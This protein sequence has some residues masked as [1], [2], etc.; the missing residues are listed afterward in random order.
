MW[1]AFLPQTFHVF[2]SGAS[3]VFSCCSAQRQNNRLSMVLCQ[4]PVNNLGQCRKGSVLTFCVAFQILTTGLFEVT[5]HLPACSLSLSTS[6][7]PS[8]W[9]PVFFFL[10]FFFFSSSLLCSPCFSFFPPPFFFHSFCLF[11]LSPSLIFLLSSVVLSFFFLSIPFL[12][13]LFYFRTFL[14]FFL[15]FY[16]SVYLRCIL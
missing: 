6:S 14:Y 2:P 5:G 15:P 4:S 11:L 3:F 1:E 12:F 7:L 10:P 8:I 16:V 9:L 13:L